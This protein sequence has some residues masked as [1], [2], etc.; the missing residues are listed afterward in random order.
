MAPAL[1]ENPTQVVKNKRILNKKADK[2]IW[3]E[4][5]NQAR[6]DGAK[7]CHWVKEAEKNDFYPFAKFNKQAEVIKYTSEEY[8][9]FIQPLNSD[10]TREETDHLLNLC[11][12]FS[13]KFIVIA[14][15][16]EYSSNEDDI[17]ESK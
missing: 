12:R 1:A 8:E 17:E 2:W 13:L 7:F 14:D 16:F 4:F 15:R 5:D 6:K 9:K 11:E 3:K 10:W